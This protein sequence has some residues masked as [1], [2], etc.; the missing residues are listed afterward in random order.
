MTGKKAVRMGKS[1]QSRSTVVVKKAV[2]PS[3]TR[4]ST[5]A[6]APS[7]H[8]A[9]IREVIVARWKGASDASWFTMAMMLGL[10]RHAASAAAERLRSTD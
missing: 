2:R 4:F 3:P 9:T 7:L 6:G 5:K 1:V 10:G 8:D